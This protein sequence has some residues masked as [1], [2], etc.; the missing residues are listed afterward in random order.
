VAT[1]VALA[2]AGVVVTLLA[3]A[4]AQHTADRARTADLLRLGAG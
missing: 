3:T 4:L 2:V 1:Y